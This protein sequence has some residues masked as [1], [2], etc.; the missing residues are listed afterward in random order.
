[1]KNKQATKKIK[2]IIAD[3]QQ[4]INR[5]LNTEVKIL[6]AGKRNP[7]TASLLFAKCSFSNVKQVEQANQ[8]CYSK[9]C[10]TCK[11]MNQTKTIKLNTA[12]EIKIKFDFTLNCKTKKYNI[13][14]FLQ[15][16]R[17]KPRILNWSNNFDL[18]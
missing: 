13:P 1:M 7:N 10:K 16:L 4:D 15:T 5:L 17:K 2:E 9:R 11:L 18:Q 6:I 8:K 12:N 14:V 3:N